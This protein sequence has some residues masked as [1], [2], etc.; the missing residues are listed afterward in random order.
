M[1]ECI[2]RGLHRYMLSGMR[3][4][5]TVRTTVALLWTCLQGCKLEGYRAYGLMVAYALK[6]L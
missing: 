3:D 1:L 4:V 5:L 6:L 2:T